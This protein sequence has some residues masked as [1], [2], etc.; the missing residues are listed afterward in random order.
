VDLA[1]LEIVLE[2]KHDR[3]SVVKFRPLI[4]QPCA[5]LDYP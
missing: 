5:M 3:G 1:Q 2:A 4:S